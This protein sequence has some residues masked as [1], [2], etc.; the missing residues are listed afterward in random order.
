MAYLDVLSGSIYSMD[1]RLSA[2]RLDRVLDA[3]GHRYRRRLL[4]ALLE[5]N[6]QDD[7]DAQNAEE[8][9][10]TVAGADTDEDAIEIELFHNHL[11]KLDDLGY[12]TWDREEGTIRKGPNWDEI[13]PVLGLLVAHADELPDGWL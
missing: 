11:P 3:L 4:V 10:G 12:I 9:L 13:E 2:V 1:K 8:A 5:H 6:P 7:D